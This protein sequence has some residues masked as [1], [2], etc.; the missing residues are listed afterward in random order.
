MT[1][2]EDSNMRGILGK[3]DEITAQAVDDDYIFRGEPE[4][5]GKITS[6]LYRHHEKEIAANSLGIEAMQEAI[7]QDAKR[8]TGETDDFEILSKLQHYGSKTNL[9][10]FTTDLHIALFFACGH[11]DKDGRVISLPTRK[12][13][14]RIT[15]RPKNRV[16]SQKSIFVQPPE[17]FIK[18]EQ[19]KV[20]S[21]PKELKPFMLDYLRKYHG[22]T[23]ESLFNDLQGFIRVQGLYYE[24]YAEFHK[25]NTSLEQKNYDGAI[26]HYTESIR[27]RPNNSSS[28]GNRGIAYWRKGDPEQ[29]LLDYNKAIE[30]DPK[31]SAVPYVN[32][33][34]LY[35]E[36]GDDDQVVKDCTEAIK[37]DS[38]FAEAYYSRGLARLHLKELD[39][40][41]MDLRN[42]ESRGINLPEE[43]K[44]LLT[45][46]QD[47]Q[48]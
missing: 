43:I 6:T 35:M 5:Y 2:P 44:A 4:C 41:R 16:V 37:L 48:G 12:V 31:S 29:A 47:S 26:R 46:Q 17:G 11:P 3:I 28:Y 14:L 27:L 18:P 22:I 30:L 45:P 25:G 38:D 7:L 36:R 40:A 24:A 9:I 23:T 19:D 42:A 13:I 21:I 33:G 34:K 1:A 39:K 15:R 8:Y 32:R 10:D 20:V